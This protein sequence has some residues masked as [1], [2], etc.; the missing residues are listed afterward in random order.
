MKGAPVSPRSILAFVASGVIAVALGGA[1]IV[2]ATASGAPRI[3]NA[4][5]LIPPAKPGPT[6]HLPTTLH[7][8]TQIVGL[9]KLGKTR[10]LLSDTVTRGS[11]RKII[12]TAAYSCNGVAGASPHEV[13][14]GAIAFS[15]GVLLIQEDLEVRSGNV[16]GAVTGGNGAYSGAQGDMT[17][18][19]EGA[20]KT[21]LTLN[22]SLG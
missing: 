20:G 12:G 6:L 10:E 16:T 14:T 19:N 11:A 8:T 13:C 17:G 18:Q 22:Y 2:G 4:P 21:V 3:P 7:L 1:V 9:V 5:A 15:D